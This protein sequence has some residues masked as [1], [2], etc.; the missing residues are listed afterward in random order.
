MAKP[1]VIEIPVTVSVEEIG[2][3]REGFQRSIS[4]QAPSAGQIARISHIRACAGGFGSAVFSW[5]PAGRERDIAVERLEEAVMW[6]V[7]AIVLEDRDA[8]SC[9]EPYRDEGLAVD[10]HLYAGHDGPHD[11][12]DFEWEDG[13]DPS[14]EGRTEA[15]STESGDGDED[16]DADDD[17]CAY[18]GFIRKADK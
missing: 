9:G 5:S 18:C 1:P 13:A 2:Q 12:G 7:K 4:H 11:C 16:C 15:H 8:E 6:A 10:C 17:N 14:P 3:T